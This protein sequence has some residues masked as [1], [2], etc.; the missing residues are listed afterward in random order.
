MRENW[1]DPC[2]QRSEV[3]ATDL[4]NCLPLYYFSHPCLEDEPELDIINNDIDDTPG[5]VWSSNYQCQ[6][7]MKDPTGQAAATHTNVSFS[8]AFLLSL[9]FVGWDSLS[10]NYLSL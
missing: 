2:A 3:N 4:K 8:R 10:V 5:S 7:Y 9:S 6:V 1:L